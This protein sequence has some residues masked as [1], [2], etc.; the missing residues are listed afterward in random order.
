MRANA[1]RKIKGR[2]TPAVTT[3]GK[4]KNPGLLKSDATPYNKSIVKLN[5]DGGHALEVVDAMEM[6]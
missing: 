3:T 2:H 5:I 6:P 4:A 1:H